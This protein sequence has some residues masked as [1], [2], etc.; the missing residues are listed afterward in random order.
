MNVELA[1]HRFVAE[2]APEDLSP[3]PLIRHGHFQLQRQASQDGR[4]DVARAICCR[5]HNDEAGR[6]LAAVWGEH[7]IPEGQ[8]LSAKRDGSLML[9]SAPVLGEK[10]INLIDEDDG[11]GELM[12]EREVGF[13]QLVG[14]STRVTERG[15]GGWLARRSQAGAVPRRDSGQA[16]RAHHFESSLAGSRQMNVYLASLA[17]ARASI[18]ESAPKLLDLLVEPSNA[19]EVDS[20]LHAEWHRGRDLNLVVVELERA[21]ELTRHVRAVTCQHLPYERCGLLLPASLGWVFDRGLV[22]VE[23]REHEQP[24]SAE[25][26]AVDE[27]DGAPVEPLAGGRHTAVQPLPASR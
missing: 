13:S 2:H 18:Q 20:L 26:G 12:S 3:C 24:S 17:T 21:S 23:E 7:P 10:A 4:V 27:H 6:C 1:S 11:R 14:L 16:A 5:H 22:W 25:D 19:R 8:K 9:T 15:C